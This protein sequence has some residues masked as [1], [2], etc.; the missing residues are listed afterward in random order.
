MS[1]SLVECVP[2]FSEGKDARKVDG[3]AA[4]IASV[5]GIAVLDVTL[6][7]D[8]NRSVITFAGSPEAAAEAAIRAVARAVE[9]IDLNSQA[10]VHPRIGAADVVPFV[11]LRNITLQACAGLATVA[12]EQIWRRLGVPVYLYEAA[13]RRADRVNLEDIR[14]G[15]FEKLRER[16]AS[17]PRWLPDFGDAA[18]HPTAGAAAVGARKLLVAF[19]INLN[20]PEVGIARDIAKKIRASSGGLPCV[21]AMGVRL[22]SRD[23][24]QVSMNLT[25]FERTPVSR[26]FAEVRDL[27]GTHGVAIAGC[28]IIGL[29]P[30]KALEGAEEWLPLV[31]GFRPEMILEDKLKLGPL[32]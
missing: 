26:V 11:P 17:D 12:G 13:A 14:R 25:D 30:K 20:T 5:E 27:A 16:V 9:S 24:A 18:L 10:G 15:G 3:I 8:H 23:L 1:G 4:S 7:P 6:D 29:I 22:E 31:E 32:E 21:K 28:E 2:N 19:N